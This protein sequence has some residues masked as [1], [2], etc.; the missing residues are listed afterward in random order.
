MADRVAVMQEGMF[1]EEA[2]PR[3]IYLRPRAAF[4]ASFLGETNLIAPRSSAVRTRMAG[5][6]YKR[7]MALY[8]SNRGLAG[9][10]TQCVDCLSPRRAAGHRYCSPGRE[11]PDGTSHSSHFCR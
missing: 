5:G 4:T 10:V 1:V 2:T 8:V 3:D 6:V 7:R 9:R 11:R